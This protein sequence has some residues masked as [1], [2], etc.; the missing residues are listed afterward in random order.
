MAKQRTEAEERAFQA[1]RQQLIR[2]SM[3]PAQRYDEAQ[4]M[5]NAMQSPAPRPY[6]EPTSTD[7]SGLTRY[8]VFRPE[9]AAE[10]A[11]NMTPVTYGGDMTDPL[12]Q[13]RNLMAQQKIEQGRQERE[14]MMGLPS[15]Q[16]MG[17]SATSRRY[18]RPEEMS[19]LQNMSFGEAQDLLGTIEQRGNAA[20][21]AQAKYA[22]DYEDAN[23]LRSR[24]SY[25]M[26][27]DM[28]VDPNAFYRASGGDNLMKLYDLTNSLLGRESRAI[29][30]A[31][32]DYAGA[33]GEQQAQSMFPQQTAMNT[34]APMSARGIGY[35]MNQP[36]FQKYYSYLTPY[37][38]QKTSF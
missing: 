27:K 25:G 36:N 6:V 4:R 21:Q 16:A 20:L 24:E 2:E 35:L 38:T 10:R 22:Q 5:V 30:Q 29:P 7:A 32:N 17:S 14:S 34:Y 23:R 19:Q 37:L 33:L 3:T 18:M 26:F 8:K 11:R 9:Y 28:G 31:Y 13:A 15:L 1:A 12:S